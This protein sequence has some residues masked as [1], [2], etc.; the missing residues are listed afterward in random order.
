MANLT[1]G[2]QI[3]FG[4]YFLA[5]GKAKQGGLLSICRQGLFFIPVLF[6]LS[7]F[8][9]LNGLIESQLVADLMSFVVTI[10]LV[11]F[12]FPKKVINSNPIEVKTK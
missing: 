1:L 11:H 3:V 2:Y 12:Y 8:F 10:V 9:G 5:I 4:T 6:L 7:R